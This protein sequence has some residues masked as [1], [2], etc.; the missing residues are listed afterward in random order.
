MHTGEFWPAVHRGECRFRKDRPATPKPAASEIDEAAAVRIAE[1]WQTCSGYPSRVLLS[2]AA[3]AWKARAEENAEALAAASKDRLIEQQAAEIAA[4][5]AEVETVRGCLHELAAT[6]RGE[7]PSL[8]NED[9]G[10]DA[11]LSM[12][13]DAA[14]GTG[15]AR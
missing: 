13:I 12:R 7:A 3:L 4:L 14:L 1:Y 8:L 11:F 6:V 9:S 15:M 5:K 2:R 10:G